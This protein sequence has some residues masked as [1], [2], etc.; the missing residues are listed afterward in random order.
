MRALDGV[1]DVAIDAERMEL[2][3]TRDRAKIDL[4]RVIGAVQE[5][6]FGAE[7]KRE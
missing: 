2:V 7:S 4:G 1:T 3:V 5:A 6:G